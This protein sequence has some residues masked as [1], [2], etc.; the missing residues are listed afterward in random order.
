[1]GQSDHD[2]KPYVQ[3][4][5]SDVWLSFTEDDVDKDETGTI[6]C[7][8]CWEAYKENEKICWSQNPQCIHTFHIE[9]IEAWLMK[10]D[11]C[12]LCRNDYL[13]LPPEVIN[14]EENPV[15]EA[16]HH[17]RG[18]EEGLP[19]TATELECTH[20]DKNR[21]M[22]RRGD[23]EEADNPNSIVADSTAG[24]MFDSECGTEQALQPSSHND[25]ESGLLMLEEL[26]E[27][28]ALSID[29]C[30]SEDEEVQKNTE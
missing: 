9:C 16:D 3:H 19:M 2:S 30:Y 21:E 1:M 26:K 8:V 25:I 23:G 6:E 28:P 15:S 12:P 22:C 5:K 29:D 11:E 24:A 14:S 13:A 20:V 17:S 18:T 10:H 27:L 4:N 7:P